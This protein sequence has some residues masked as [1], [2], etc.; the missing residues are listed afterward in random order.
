MWECHAWPLPMHQTLTEITTQLQSIFVYF[1]CTIIYLPVCTIK[2]R[3][4]LNIHCLM[5]S[6][7]IIGGIWSWLQS[8]LSGR[9]QCVSTVSPG[10][11][12]S[13]QASFRAASWVHCFSLPMLIYLKELTI[14]QPTYV[15]ISERV[16]NFTTFKFADDHALF[17]Y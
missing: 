5:R 14:L 4:S 13:S 17:Y 6:A 9:S 1:V 2:I 12:Q 15:D 10:L 16:N 7:G 11:Y 8:C 3:Q